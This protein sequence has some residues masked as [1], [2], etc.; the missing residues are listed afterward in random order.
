MKHQRRQDGIGSV[1]YEQRHLAGIVWRCSGLM[2]V[3]MKLWYIW[4][5]C[6]YF[7][8]RQ[9]EDG[10]TVFAIVVNMSFGW[11]S[12]SSTFRWKERRRRRRAFTH[13]KRKKPP[14]KRIRL[15]VRAHR[16]SI[17]RLSVINRSWKEASSEPWL[18]TGDEGVAM[19]LCV[20]TLPRMKPNFQGLVCDSCSGDG[21]NHVFGIERRIR[22]RILMGQ[23][24]TVRLGTA[25]RRDAVQGVTR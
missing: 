8:K 1:L 16:V 3:Q 14:A 13:K 21:T 9:P 6:F 11:K 22:W 20:G 2:V 25:R 19:V 10:G 15:V 17:K 5:I 12:L 24:G 23:P 7:R 18:K 4:R